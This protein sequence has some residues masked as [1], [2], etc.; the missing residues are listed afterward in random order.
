MGIKL[1]DILSLSWKNVFYHKKRSITVIITV[2]IL[3]ATI[4]SYSILASS[5]EK[6]AISAS[7]SQTKSKIYLTVEARE[8]KS[9]AEKTLYTNS[10]MSKLNLTPVIDQS[11]LEGVKKGD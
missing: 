2:S 7:M 9:A 8:E 10:N 6:I 11:F 4:L 1:S 5:I 3:F